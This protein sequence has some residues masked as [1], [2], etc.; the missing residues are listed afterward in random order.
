MLLLTTSLRTE[1][2]EHF[3]VS[4]RRKGERHSRL[5]DVPGEVKCLALGHTAWIT[6]EKDPGL[7]TPGSPHSRHRPKRQTITWGWLPGEARL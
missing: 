5:A 6:V 7:L 2:L 3:S 1:T 4:V